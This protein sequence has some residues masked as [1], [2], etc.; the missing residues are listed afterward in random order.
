MTLIFDASIV[1][2]FNLMNPRR[3][4]PP[5][6]CEVKRQRIGKKCPVSLMPQTLGKQ[7]LLGRQVSVLTLTAMP[8]L[9]YIA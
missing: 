1:G 7:L 6:A 9:K 4:A 8:Q 3:P 2:I 5:F